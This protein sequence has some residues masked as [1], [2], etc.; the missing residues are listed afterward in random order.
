MA[1]LWLG[2]GADAVESADRRPGDPREVMR[3]LIEPLDLPLVL[4]DR[5]RIIAA[6]A[7]AREA[8][9]GHIVGQDAR[10]ALAPS[11]GGRAC[12]TCP[13]AAA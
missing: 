12:S 7:A 9:G 8:L 10:I 2:A 5:E 1:S 11:R 4:F 13:T 6:N 3:D